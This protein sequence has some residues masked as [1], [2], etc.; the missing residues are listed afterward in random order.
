MK[1]H[2]RFPSR[3]HILTAG[4]FTGLVLAF[5]E[6]AG[7]IVLDGEVGP[8]RLSA[9]NQRLLIDIGHAHSMKLF[10]DCQFCL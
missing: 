10:R 4:A 3:R 2:Y 1:D 5:Q 6:F 9:Q 8:P 7:G